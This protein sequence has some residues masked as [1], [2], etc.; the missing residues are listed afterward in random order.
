VVVELVPLCELRELLA[1]GLC[2]FG[3]LF[4]NELFLDVTRDEVVVFE[5][6]PPYLHVLPIEHGPKVA[7]RFA[8]NKQHMPNALIFIIALHWICELPLHFSPHI[9]FDVLG[10]FPL[11]IICYGHLLP[12]YTG[13]L[14]AKGADDDSWLQGLFFRPNLVYHMCFLLANLMLPVLAP[15]QV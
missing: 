13:T 7:K 12:N 1:L 6:C 9:S 10:D 2:F 4:H 3:R 5:W 8:Y 15:L 14:V 11:I